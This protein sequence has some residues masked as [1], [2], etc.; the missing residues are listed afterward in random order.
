MTETESTP[1]AVSVVPV[2]KPHSKLIEMAEVFLR[3]LM[4]VLS[5]T[6]L[7]LIATSEQT[8]TIMV[9]IPGF[10]APVPVPVTAKF[11]YLPQVVY[12]VVAVSAF[13]LYG[14]IT[15]LVSLTSLIKFKP[16]FI[17]KLTIYIVILDV[18]F[19]GIMA[20]AGGAAAGASYI[21]FKGNKHTG[22]Q[23]LCHITSKFCWQAGSGV[24]ISLVASIVQLLLIVLFVVS[25]YKK[26]PNKVHWQQNGL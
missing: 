16:T 10:P 8:K 9:P 23:K 22:W 11:Q 13:I 7:V 17:S 4:V 2:P 24:V 20:S 3:I 1:V 21:G 18:L 5:I 25:Q 19:L 14:I 12:L 6:A 26:I 15:T